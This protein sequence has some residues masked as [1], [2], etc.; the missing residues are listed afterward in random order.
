MTIVPDP[1]GYGYVRKATA[2]RRVLRRVADTADIMRAA[3]YPVAGF[4]LLLCAAGVPQ[5][6]HRG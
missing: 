4:I 5:H 6:F 2:T 3:F 1:S